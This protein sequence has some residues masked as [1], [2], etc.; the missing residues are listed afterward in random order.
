MTEDDTAQQNMHQQREADE[1][2]VDGLLRFHYPAAI[3]ERKRR[4]EQTLEAL[5]ADHLTDQHVSDHHRNR[6]LHTRR[7]R[8]WSISIAALIVVTNALVLIGLPSGSSAL[9]Q[10]EQSIETLKNPGMVRYEAWMEFSDD[11]TDAGTTVAYIDMNS[12]SSTIICHKPPHHENWVTV[13]RDLDGEWAISDSGQLTRDD[14]HRHFPPWSLDDQTLLV[15]SIDKVL[16]QLLTNYVLSKPDSIFYNQT[17]ETLTRV[18]ARYNGRG[19]GPKP[20]SVT[21]LIHPISN[22]PVRIEF[23]WDSKAQHSFR[24]PPP[25]DRGRLSPPK[26]RFNSGHHKPDHEQQSPPPPF[27]ADMNETPEHPGFDQ[28]NI[29][30][31]GPRGEFENRRPHQM[32]PQ[33][34]QGGLRRLVFE[35]RTFPVDLDSNWFSAENHAFMP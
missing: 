18:V 24:P 12:A 35:L 3:S 30:R 27:N 8:R 7:L 9:A 20:D 21:V 10:V 34:D 5:H 32:A 19:Q 17:G 6:A 25:Q 13:G 1:H 2:V 22:L 31:D 16:E 4:L 14:A 11:E 29:D 23:G 15:D 33:N 26:P 28:S